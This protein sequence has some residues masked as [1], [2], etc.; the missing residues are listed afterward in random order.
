MLKLRKY[1]KKK[2]STYISLSLTI[3]ILSIIIAILLITFL[4]NKFKKV[5]LPI[6]ISDTRKI[7]TMV[8][9]ASV[10]DKVMNMLK[11]KEI[12]TIQ[13]DGENINM[14]NYNSY[15]VNRLLREITYNIENSFKELEQGNIDALNSS[16][17]RNNNNLLK[18]G[19]IGSVPLGIIFDNPILNNIGPYIDIKF[20]YLGDIKSNIETSIKPYGINNALI[21]LSVFVEVSSQ[22]TLPLVTERVTISNEI[23]ISINIIEGKVPEGYIY[24]YK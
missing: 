10:T 18:K 12:Y 16:L 1:K 23:P 14:I 11:E 20:T 9:N 7:V 3:I 21:S 4:S 24:S 15:E 22:I 19:T 17:S 5:L 13:Y 8:I 2:I 6:A